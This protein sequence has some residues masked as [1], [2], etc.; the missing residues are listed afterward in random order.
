MGVKKLRELTR[1]TEIFDT[2]IIPIASSTG[3]LQHAQVGDLNLLSDADKVKFDGIEAGAEKNTVTSVS[4]KTGAV[5]L[6]KADVGLSNVDNTSDLQKPISTATQSALDDKEGSIKSALTK[7]SIVDGDTIVISDSA[8][9]NTTKRVTFSVLKST[10]KA[11]FDTLYTKYVLPVATA[12]ALGGVKS[13]TDITVDSSGNVSVNDDSHNHIVGNIDGLQDAL[14]GKL[15]STGN[16]ASAAKLY[17]PRAINGVSFDGTKDITITAVDQTARDSA[18]AA[19]SS[20]NEKE[21]AF[22]KNTAFNKNFGTA[23]WTVCQGNDT[24]LSDARPADGGTSTSAHYLLESDT[25]DSNNPPSWYMLNVGKRNIYEFK[26]NSVIGLTISG[27]PTFSEVSTFTSWGDSSGGFPV[28]LATNNSGIYYRTSKDVSTWNGWVKVTNDSELSAVAKSGNYTDL[29]NTPTSLPANGGTAAACSGN[30]ST[31]SKI[32]TPRKIAG[33]LF[34][35][36]ADISIP[37]DNITGIP[38]IPPG[39]TVINNLTSTSPTASLSANM[40]KSLNDQKS[41]K[42][43]VAQAQPIG[44][45]TD[46]IWEEVIQ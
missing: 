34:D 38:T 3:G 41:N 30:A 27:V 31:A 46:D 37:Y 6:S 29:K 1:K 14:N 42:P 43:V 16:A 18:A 4:G 39:V 28:Q 44:Q 22:T 23:A 33:V 24:R 36:S 17:T 26:T 35:G 45:Q 21:A 5:Q 12:S 32:Q 2:D 8:T 25:R 40:G 15:S 20:A 13:G 9:T 10:L 19:Q 11:Y 7:S